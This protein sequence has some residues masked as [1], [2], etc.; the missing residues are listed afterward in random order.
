MTPAPS[1]FALFHE[2]FILDA[3]IQKKLDESQKE[4]ITRNLVSDLLTALRMDP[5]GDLQIFDA[6]D[7][8][9]PGW[10]FLIPITTSHIG[11][12]Y[13]ESPG[14]LPNL[15]IDT[16]SC[17]S[18]NWRKLIDI[19]HKHIGLERWRATFIDRQIG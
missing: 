4:S 18:V 13:F 8:R 2:I 3:Y 1:N 11:G 7:L 16:Y 5:L 12:H 10:S 14:R 19:L 6:A 17:A 9:A 15:R